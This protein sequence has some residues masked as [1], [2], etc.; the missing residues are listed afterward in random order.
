MTSI[1]I[2]T[3]KVNRPCT[4]LRHRTRYIACD[5]RLLRFKNP[6]GYRS[7]H[8]GRI[9][10]QSDIPKSRKWTYIG[11]GTT[12]CLGLTTLMVMGNTSKLDSEDQDKKRLEDPLNQL[13]ADHLIAR[14]AHLSARSTAELLR[15]Y[16]TFFMCEIPALVDYGPKA[17]ESYM[18]ACEAIPIIGHLGWLIAA[19]I[20]RQTFFAH[21]TGGETAEACWPVLQSLH[22][23]G[24]GTLMNYSA[25][26]PKLAPG[27]PVVSGVSQHHIDANLAAV[28]AATQFGRSSNQYPAGSAPIRPTTVAIKLSGLVS[29]PYVFERA[30][31]YLTDQHISPYKP[32]GELFPASSTSN[33]T[34]T[35]SK[36]DRSTMESLLTELRGICREAKENNVIVMID[37]EYSWFQ[38]AIDRLATFLAAEFNRSD[39]SKQ[40]NQTTWPTVYN[41]FQALLRSTP[42]RIQEA[43]KLA[44]SHGYS[45]GIKLVRGAYL[46]AETNHW[47]TSKIPVW[48]NKSQ[49][50]DC[51]DQIVSSLTSRLSKE[52]KESKKKPETRIGLMIAGHNA[53]SAIKVLTQLRDQEGLAHNLVENGSNKLAMNDALRGRLMFAQLYGMA[54]QLTSALSEILVSPNQ[55]NQA[56]DLQPFVQKCLPF[57][58][59]S[60]TIP[61]LAR[62]AQE[63][64]SVLQGSGNG[65]VGRAT[66]ER[67]VVGQE[68]RRR[69]LKVFGLV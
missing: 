49:T 32:T 63:N 59:I 1:W 64:K 61:Y 48:S 16:F 26:A 56:I 38:P 68:L 31:S 8:S 21:Y 55:T 36:D 53:D 25:E 14:T 12:S 67:R 29:D 10:S 9:N 66:L 5:P 18:A 52:I 47:E 39:G 20:M 35:L 13:Q 4:A 44:D 54:D 15:S 22:S 51:F 27:S 17:L 69:V 40:S 11:L 58:S 43:I 62:R 57:G 46:V 60:E 65:E 41:T 19:T 42:D 45:I 6:Q 34:S 37:A 33:G 50:D 23:Q 28:A 7:N 2:S 30:S 24:V 3:L